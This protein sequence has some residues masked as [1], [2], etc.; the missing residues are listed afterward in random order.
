MFEYVQER[1]MGSR[2]EPRTLIY[3]I[4]SGELVLENSGRL[5]ERGKNQ[6]LELANSRLVSGVRKICTSSSSSELETAKILSK[7]FDVRLDKKGCLDG[8]NPGVSWTDTEQLGEVLTSLWN[9]HYFK[10]GKGESIEEAKERFGTCM[11]EIGQ[12]HPTDSIAVVCDTIMSC[13]FYSLVT[14][15]PLSI[16]AWLSTGF[17]SCATYEY[18]KTGWT[19]VM[20]PENSYL[21]DPS[22]VSQWLPENLF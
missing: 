21:S 5:T 18:A 17:A 2:L 13:L 16:E 14:A 20:P 4:T 1:E 15:A 7:E 22:Y 9:D 6:I 8:F 10:N 3:V 11:N 19:L 12:K